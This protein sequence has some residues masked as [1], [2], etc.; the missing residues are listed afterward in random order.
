VSNARAAV[1]RRFQPRFRGR[2]GA[3]VR[4]RLGARSRYASIARAPSATMERAIAARRRRTSARFAE[5]CAEKPELP[6]IAARGQR[7]A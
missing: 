1:D 4:R 6:D 2:R 5:R 3:E 7:V